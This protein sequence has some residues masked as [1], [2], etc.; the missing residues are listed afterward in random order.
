MICEYENSFV[1][2]TDDWFN[3]RAQI[4]I[5]TK[6]KYLKFPRRISYEYKSSENYDN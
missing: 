1:D 3:R 2:Y 5:R 6:K 4:E